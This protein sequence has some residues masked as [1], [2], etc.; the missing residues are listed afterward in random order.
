MS[1]RDARRIYLRKRAFYDR[2]QEELS[3]RPPRRVEAEVLLLSAA[4]EQ[5][6]AQD[7]DSNGAF[8]RALLDVWDGGRFQGTYIDFHAR[9]QKRLKGIQR[10]RILTLRPPSFSGQRPFTI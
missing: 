10:P 4:E 7:G 6:T 9:I 3:A 5:E 1:S 8:T 2:I